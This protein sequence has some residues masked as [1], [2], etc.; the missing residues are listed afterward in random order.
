MENCVVILYIYSSPELKQIHS[1]L[2]VF[3]DLMSFVYPIC[4]VAANKEF[5]IF[6]SSSRHLDVLTSQTNICKLTFPSLVGH[7]RVSE[8]LDYFCVQQKLLI[9][10]WLWT[11]RARDIKGNVVETFHRESKTLREAWK[12]PWYWF[13]LTSHKAVWFIL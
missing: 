1:A 8:P 6:K 12:Q 13:G 10:T 7:C 3:P 4:Y 5:W 11:R 9:R 2:E